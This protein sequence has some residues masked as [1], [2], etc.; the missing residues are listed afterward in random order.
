MLFCPLPTSFPE[1]SP[2]SEISGSYPVSAML[3]LPFLW[4]MKS[5]KINRNNSALSF[6]DLEITPVLAAA[7]SFANGLSDPSTTWLS[8][9]CQFPHVSSPQSP[10]GE[11][12]T[13][14]SFYLVGLSKLQMRL[15]FEGHS[16]R[17][18]NPQSLHLCNWVFHYF[19][20][21]CLRTLLFQGSWI[22]G[23][24]S[25]NFP[26]PS[27]KSSRLDCFQPGTKYDRT[28]QNP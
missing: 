11:D 15:W 8:N 18:I 10:S 14:T 7:E 12:H 19:S 1:M 3:P 20:A 4:M 26:D 6:S 28:N 9:N 5:P 2:H 24:P 17:V 23:I 27:L 13:D 22:V 25:W 21:V 16:W